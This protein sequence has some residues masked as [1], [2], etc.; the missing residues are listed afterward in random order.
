LLRPLQVWMA[1]RP[2]LCSREWP[3]TVPHGAFTRPS[4]TAARTLAGL[5]RSSFGLV[6]VVGTLDP[7]DSCQS[8]R[9]ASQLASA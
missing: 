5:A 8:V 9:Y 1:K 6:A 4:S 3:V 7:S 2:K